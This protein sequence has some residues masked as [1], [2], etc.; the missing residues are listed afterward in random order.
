MPVW[1]GLKETLIDVLMAKLVGARLYAGVF[2]ELM[3]DRDASAF[4]A[5]RRNVRQT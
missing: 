3:V 2:S 1:T 4:L 5:N